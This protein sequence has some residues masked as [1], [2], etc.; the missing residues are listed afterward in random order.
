VIIEDENGREWTTEELRDDHREPTEPDPEP[1][2]LDAID[3]AYEASL[4]EWQPNTVGPNTANVLWTVLQLT[5]E[6]RGYREAEEA[7]AELPTR[8]EWTV[9]ARADEPPSTD[10][11]WQLDPENAELAYGRAGGQ[12]WC[13]NLTIGNPVAISDQAPF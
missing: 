10:A 2:D 12:L 6:L 8:T 3:A 11:L 1:L 4:A 7:W 9:T 13:R 5:S